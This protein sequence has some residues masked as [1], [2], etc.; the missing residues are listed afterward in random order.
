MLFYAGSSMTLA[1]DQKR[2]RQDLSDT[3]RRMLELRNAVFAQWEQ[4]VRATIPNAAV[5]QHPILIDTLPAYYDNI[6]EAVTATFPRVTAAGGTS[7]A[8]EHG[9]ERARITAYDYL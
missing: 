7:L 5:L 1:S 9:G 6:A 8:A 3:S 4:Q 2:N